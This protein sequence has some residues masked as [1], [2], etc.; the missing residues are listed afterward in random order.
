[1]SQFDSKEIDLNLLRKRLDKLLRE[2]DSDRIALAYAPE[3]NQTESD[4]SL[5]CFIDEDVEIACIEEE[6]YEKYTLGDIVD[7]FCD[8]LKNDQNK[9]K[10]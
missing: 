8:E 5:S 9:G 2:T 7:W 1:M 4:M 3:D 6:D 10:A